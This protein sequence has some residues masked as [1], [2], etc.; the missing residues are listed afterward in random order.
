MITYIP[1]ALRVLIGVTGASFARWI[2]LLGVPE[3]ILS[4]ASNETTLDLK[5]NKI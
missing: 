2:L 3:Y 1:I 4:S 5:V